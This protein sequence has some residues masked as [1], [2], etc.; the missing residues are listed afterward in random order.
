MNR[1]CAVVGLRSVSL[2]CV[3]RIIC[4]SLMVRVLALC[5]KPLSFVLLVV[6]IIIEPEIDLVDVN[7]SFL[8]QLLPCFFLSPRAMELAAEVVD[9]LL[10]DELLEGPFVDALCSVVV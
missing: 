2:P 3:V 10:G 8:C 9:G 4:L 5:I 7:S 1:T 6:F